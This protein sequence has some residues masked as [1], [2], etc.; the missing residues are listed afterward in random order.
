MLSS[1]SE[2]KYDYFVR[3]DGSKRWYRTGQP[4]L[5]ERHKDQTGTTILVEP[6]KTSEKRKGFFPKWKT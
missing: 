4:V 6:A 2:G 1:A 3:K 5:G